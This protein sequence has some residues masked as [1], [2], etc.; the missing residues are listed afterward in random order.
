MSDKLSVAKLRAICRKMKLTNY[1]NLNKT[2]LIRHIQYNADCIS[3][4][5]ITLR[6]FQK[7]AVATLMH[8]T[9]GLLLV[10]NTG[11]GK[12]L[13]AV[14][15]SQCFLS[16][17][18]KGNVIVVTPASLISN[19]KKEMKQ[20]GVKNYNKYLFYSYQKFCSTPPRKCENTLLILDEAHRLRE[21]SS[22]TS[23]AALRV[24]TKAK[25][26]LLLTA[27]PFINNMY[28]LI[29]L[30]NIL[31][32]KKV[33]TNKD[34]GKTPDKES[35]KTLKT[36]F[37]KH[38]HYM[39]KKGS[40]FPK[41]IEKYVTLAMPSPYHKMYLKLLRGK[42]TDFGFSKP[43][44]FYNGHRRAVNKVSDKYFS[45][46]IKKM[47]TYI[48]NGQSLIYT[49]WVAFGLDPI[50]KYLDMKNVSYNYISGNLPKE[51]RGDI[52]LD[53]NKEKFQVL[54]ITQA[55]SE[56]LDLK[57]VQNVIV[58]EPQWNDA[59]LRQVIGRAVRYKSHIHLPKSKQ[60]VR[61]FKMILTC[62]GYQYKWRDDTDSGDAV[63]YKLM[64][65]KADTTE[66]VMKMLKQSSI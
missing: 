17:Y 32:Q 15:A 41:V 51:K 52:V 50:K 55:G 44:A 42:K 34:I 35:L 48:K 8:R 29:P 7:K 1:T 25:K 31:H 13:T 60:V 26:I 21:S 64:E 61:V 65:N 39:Y 58:M 56:G 33:L 66:D 54:I 36:Y 12:T 2:Q 57:G 9:N 6:N 40:N 19:F 62:P 38:V 46:K 11:L 53:F 59:G 16:S 5:S 23:I 27:T 3:N 18:K 45:L 24:A 4:S 22:Y 49:N 20:Y 28:D 43:E 30:V 63:L 10:Y 37:D 47:M 14:T